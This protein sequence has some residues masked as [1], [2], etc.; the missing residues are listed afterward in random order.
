MIAGIVF[1]LSFC[2]TFFYLVTDGDYKL[3]AVLVTICF[4]IGAIGASIAGQ[5]ESLEKKRGL[6]ETTTSIHHLDDEIK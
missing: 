4:G 6:D 3:A 1:L 2:G 5:V